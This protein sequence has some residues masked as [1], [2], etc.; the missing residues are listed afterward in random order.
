MYTVVMILVQCIT[1]FGM[2]PY[3]CNVGSV[4]YGI[5]LVPIA[6]YQQL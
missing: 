5:E 2:Q 1:L 4:N 3:S 6:M